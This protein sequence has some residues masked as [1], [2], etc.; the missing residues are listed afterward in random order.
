[1]KSSFKWFALALAVTL[2][3]AAQAHKF[4]MVPS[5][6]VLSGGQDNWITVDAAVSNDLFY[7]NHHALALDNLV[8]TGPDGATVKPE[9]AHTGKWRSTFDVHL[10]KDGSYKLAIVNDGLFASYE[11][12]GQRKRWRGSA[13]ELA[14]LPA[15]AKNLKV[16]ES[17]SRLESF[18]TVGSPTTTALKPTNRGLELVPVTHP[19]DLYSGEEARFKLLL[20]GQPAKGIAVSV[21]PGGTRYR[22]SQNEIKATTGDDGV[23]AVTWPVAGMYWLSARSEDAKV[24]S[25]RASER[26]LGYVATLEVLPQ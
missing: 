1:M 26:R 2:P 6:T 22:N 4:F 18:V 24:S 25:P 16:S 20:D 9:N 14:K 12:N 11:E 10:Q 15:D 13:A 21:I 19:N 7:F 3:L 5:Q 23:F 17:V 8:I